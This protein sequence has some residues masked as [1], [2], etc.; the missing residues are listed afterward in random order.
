MLTN[1]EVDN[2]I[3]AVKIVEGDIT[4]SADEDHSPAVEFRVILHSDLGR[5][6]FIKGSYNPTAETLTYAVIDKA[7]GCIYRLDLG[8]EHR[9]PDRALIGETH[10]HKWTEQHGIRWAYVPKDITE[11]ASD[12]VSVWQQLCTEF[13]ITHNG[14]LH[15]PGPQQMSIV[16]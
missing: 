10:K 7:S 3:Q 6:L 13:N 16:I 5:S 4:W 11:P 9:N 15:P 14:R 1:Q 2:I 12:P 8:K